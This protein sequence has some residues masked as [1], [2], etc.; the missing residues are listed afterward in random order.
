[1][2]STALPRR[3]FL[4]ASAIGLTS[5]AGG[6]VSAAPPTTTPKTAA[7]TTTTTAKKTGPRFRPTGRAGLGGVAIGNGFM[8]VTNDEQAT[9]T[10]QAAWDAGVRTFDT[11]PF[12]GFGLSERRFG[13]VLHQH[14]RDDYVLCTKVGRVF[15]ATTGTLP[16]SLWA[17]PSPFRYRYDYSA[18]GVLRSIEDSL[19]RLGVSR[20]DVVFVHDLSRDTKDL[21]FEPAFAEA[22]RGAF[23]ALSKLRDEGVIKAWGLGVNTAEPALRAL[24]VADPDIFLLATQYSLIEHQAS[25]T[26]T[27]PK[28]EARGASVV[29]G[30]PLNAGFLAGR[31]RFN[32]GESIPADVKAKRAKL[33]AVAATHKVDLRTAALQFAAAPSV[34]SAIVPGA[35]TAEQVKEN[36]ASMKTKI[37]AA[38][39]QQ[40]RADKL[41]A[42]TAPVP[43]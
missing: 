25:L 20:L 24:D 21:D 39:W 37:P 41:I 5:I 11:S 1:M 7:K 3:G 14:K 13:H 19:N 33:Q 6:T 10:L 35:R 8:K 43:A 32:Y 27:F 31:D 38:F 40:L 2:T 9:A 28:I 22:T 12:Y 17:E 36:M 4:A 26:D 34:V 29:V 30:S 18:D 15:T 23:V 16:K 42:E